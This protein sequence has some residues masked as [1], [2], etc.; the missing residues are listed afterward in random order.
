MERRPAQPT[1][2]GSSDWFSGDVYVD[3]IARS[4]STP[5]V[6]LGCV[7]FTPCAHTAWHRHSAG[8]RSTAAKAKASSKHAADPLI[9]LR[10]GDIVVTEPGEWHWPK[11]RANGSW[12]TWPS[13][14]ATPNGATTSP[15]TSTRRPT[16]E[17][18]GGAWHSAHQPRSHPASGTTAARYSGNRRFTDRHRSASTSAMPESTR[19]PPT[20]CVER[21]V[22]RLGYIGVSREANPP[23]SLG[24][25]GHPKRRC[26]NDVP[27]QR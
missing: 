27:S 20:S 25:A 18:N 13:P 16:P 3:A 19:P 9:R 10:P 6:T 12:S 1:T 15:T 17:T 11:R 22:P 21:P 4:Q 8:Q 2:K 26:T 23:P 14:A 24:C 7:H 5:P